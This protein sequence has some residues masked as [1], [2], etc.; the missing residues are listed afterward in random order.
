[1]NLTV[2]GR[3]FVHVSFTVSLTRLSGPVSEA[4]DPPEG[5]APFSYVFDLTGEIRVDRIE[6]VGLYSILTF[7]SA[8]GM[9]K[10]YCQWDL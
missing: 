7:Y 2:A 9:R 4:F 5:Q 6:Q 1:M 10:D 8:H 3:V